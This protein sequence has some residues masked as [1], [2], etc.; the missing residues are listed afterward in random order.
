MIAK[1]VLAGFLVLAVMVAFSLPA[2]GQEVVK[3]K[4]DAL[5]K[6]AKKITIGGTEYSLSE[7][8]AQADVAVG[9]E[10]EATVEGGTVK[11]FVKT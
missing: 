1:K 6:D 9:D 7:E 3:G 8:A 5:D 10:V 11:T 2:F 4:I